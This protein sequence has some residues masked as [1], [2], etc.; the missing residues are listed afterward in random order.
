MK[1]REGKGIYSFELKFLANLTTD[2]KVRLGTGGLI[3]EILD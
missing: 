2:F 3:Q 1:G